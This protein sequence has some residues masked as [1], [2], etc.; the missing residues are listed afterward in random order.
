MHCYCCCCCC[1]ASVVSDSVQPRRW[2]PT[3]LPCPWDSPGKN[4][5]VGCY[6]LLQGTFPTQGL[7]LHLLHLLHWQA[8]SLTTV[9]PGNP[10][11]MVVLF[12]I[13]LWK[14]CT[15][16]HTGCTKL[17]SLVGGDFNKQGNLFTKLVLGSLKTSSS[18]H[19]PIRIVKIYLVALTGFICVLMASAAPYLLKD[20]SWEQLPMWEW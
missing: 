10:D 17:H 1:V 19:L 9:P 16:L 8:D 13:F 12:F 6:F 11:H 18:P 14:L 20:E 3:R 5:G 4:T 7:N 15:V 2:Q